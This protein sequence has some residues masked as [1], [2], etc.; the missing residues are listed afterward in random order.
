[1]VGIDILIAFGLGTASGILAG[2]SVKLIVDYRYRPIIRIEEDDIQRGIDLTEDD[3][4]RVRFVAHRV[5]V[6]NRGKTAA[7]S[8]IAG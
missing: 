4:S 7:E 5:V 3:G 2:V 8:H 1:M 6:R